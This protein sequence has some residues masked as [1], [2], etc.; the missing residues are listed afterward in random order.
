MLDEPNTY[1]GSIVLRADPNRAYEDP[2]IKTIWDGELEFPV[3]FS[4]L[5]EA[6]NSH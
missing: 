3:S 1:T 4:V 6:D 2:A 5:A